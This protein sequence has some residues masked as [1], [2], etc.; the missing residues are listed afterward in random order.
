[1]ICLLGKNSDCCLTVYCLISPIRQTLQLNDKNMEA[2][3]TACPNFP[4]NFRSRLMTSLKVACPNHLKTTDSKAEGAA[5]SFT[6]L[7]FVWYNRY[8]AN[9]RS[10]F[11][12]H[13]LPLNPTI[14][15]GEGA[16]AGVDPAVLKRNGKKRLNTSQFTPRT[17]K[18]LQENA[19]EY[20][21]LQACFNDVFK[22]MHDTVFFLILHSF[23]FLTFFSLAQRNFP[24][25]V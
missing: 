22:W 19:P 16:S 8:S 18:E 11:L 6:A 14:I 25:G 21:H 15:Q 12:T 17:S 1:M 2:F 3:L 5:H 24:K 9:V 4:Q 20:Q 7:H 23:F 10:L 13:F